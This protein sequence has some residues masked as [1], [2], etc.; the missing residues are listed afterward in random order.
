MHQDEFFKIVGIIIVCF[1]IIYMAVNMFYLQTKVIEGLT[2]SDETTTT[3]P[4]SGEAGTAGSY[5]AAVKAQVVKLQD[6]LLISKY[7][8][9]YEAA[10]INLDDY[11]GF[12]MLK[13]ALNLKM[14]DDNKANFEIIGKLNAL[15]SAKDSLNATMTFL[16][17]Q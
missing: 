7:R 12:N 16:D 5:A 3:A 2:N 1:F 17:K 11:F 6:E 9:D 15:K 8:K 10:I 13:L 4:S 14:S